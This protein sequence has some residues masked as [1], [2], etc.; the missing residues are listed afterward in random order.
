VLAQLFSVALA[1]LITRLYV[2]NNF[3]QMALF[4]SFF[5]VALVTASLRYEFAIVSAR[6]NREAAHLTFCSF[7]LSLPV[8]AGA[9]VIFY[10]LVR[11]GIFGYGSMPVYAAILIVPAMI[12]AACFSALRYWLL[13]QE[14][15]GL[16]SRGTVAQNACR[17]I[18]QAGLGA[19]G[20]HTAGLLAG[21]IIGRCSGMT[22]MLR[23]AWPV[24]HR[25]LAGSDFCQLK[26]ALKR[27]RHFALYSLPSSLLDT[28]G[29]SISFPLVVYFYGLNTGG[30]YALVARTLA[31][32]AVLIT[33]NVAD[34][35]HSRA[36]LMLHQ[37]PKALPGFVKHMATVLF[38][39]GL[40]PAVTLVAFGPRLFEWVF[41]GKWV[42]AGVMA[43]WTAPWFLAQ[44]VV[45]PLS[46]VVLVVGRQ[47]VK[48][49]YDILTFGGTIAVFAIAH[50]SSW[51]VM[52]LIAALTGLKTTAYVVFFMLLLG[53]SST[54]VHGTR[55]AM[56]D[57]P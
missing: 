12:G 3:G 56:E 42:E 40:F 45:S 19:M 30:S 32:P 50:H 8:S 7:L 6:D 41:G 35:F 39:F 31:L 33:A 27:N 29:G 44:F 51:P 54:P 43:A 38:L 28:L 49:I 34:A 46:R 21:E 52:T 14:R 11:F 2:P 17:A 24:L 25:E 57:S 9:G 10:L 16:I 36:A 13:R 48:F 22:R 26:D 20:P 18:A 15:F 23:A 5:N 1:P 4:I 53:I 55:V 47:E 37:N